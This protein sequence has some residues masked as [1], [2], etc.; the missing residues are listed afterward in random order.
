LASYL[1]AEHQLKLWSCDTVDEVSQPE[2]SEKEF[3]T[4]LE[5]KC[6]E[7]CA[8]EQEKLGDAFAKKLATVDGQ[9]QRAGQKVQKEKGQRWQKIMNAILSFITTV[10]GAFTGGRKIASQRNISA[11]STA[12]RRAGSIASEQGDIQHAEENLEGLQRKKADLEAQ[13]QTVLDEIAAKYDVQKLTLS[14]YLIRPRK[15]DIS[16]GKVSLTWVPFKVDS[17]GIAERVC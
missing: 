17:T 5:A 14:E 2:E 6:K 7:E 15:G 9:I 12:A 11:A 13:Q 3:R 1:Y 8:A 16:V 4:R 10:L